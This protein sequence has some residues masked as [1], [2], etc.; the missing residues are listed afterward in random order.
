M[1]MYITFRGPRGRGTFD[2]RQVRQ[3]ADTKRG[4]SRM[5][6]YVL[7]HGKSDNAPTSNTSSPTSQCVYTFHGPKRRCTLDARQSQTM[8]R[9]QMCLESKSKTHVTFRAPRCRETFDARQLGRHADIK[10][11]ESEIKMCTTFRGPRRS[12][13]FDARQVKR[14]AQA[15]RVPSKIK[16]ARDV[17]RPEPKRCV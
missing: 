14:W 17:S 3:R 2:A 8:C 15:K 7:T 4:D 9:G 13:T 5:K 16:N 1:K 6:M 11:V 12:G 10:R